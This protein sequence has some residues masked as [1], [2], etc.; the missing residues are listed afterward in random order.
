V[1]NLARLMPGADTSSRTIK[2]RIAN[3]AV[4]PTLIAH[5]T[6]YAP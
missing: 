3:N 1:G 6:A 2:L 4:S 5:V